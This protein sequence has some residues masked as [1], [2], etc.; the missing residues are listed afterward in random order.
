MG[1]IENVINGWRKAGVALNPGATPESLARLEAALGVALPEDVVTYFSTMNGMD[2]SHTAEWL[3]S[4]WSIEKILSQRVE[5]EGRD[6]AG[7][8]KE[9]AFA[10]VMIDSWFLWLR[11]R[12][13]GRLSIFVEGSDEEQLSLA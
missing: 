6:A 4:F 7:P 9:L 3:S 1:A 8:Y 11:V 13:G 10:D 12:P 5:R 2:D